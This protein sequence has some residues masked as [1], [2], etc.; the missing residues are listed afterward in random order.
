MSLRQHQK[1]RCGNDAQRHV[2]LRLHKS[3]AT[4]WRAMSARCSRLRRACR[5]VTYSMLSSAS[6]QISH[7]CFAGRSALPLLFVSVVANAREPAP[8]PPS[9]LYG[10]LFHRVQTEETF[11]RQQDICRCDGESR[12]P[13][14]SCA[15][16]RRARISRDFSLARFRG[17]ELRHSGR[18]GQRFQD[19]A[20]RRSARARRSA[21]GRADAGAAGFARRGF[22]ASADDPL[23]GAG[24]TLSRAVLL[25]FLLHDGGPADQR[26]STIS[27][28]TWSKTSPASSIATGTSRMAAAAT[29]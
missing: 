19:H 17:R 29:T 8:R 20:A 13:R 18:R 1:N 27:W 12:R 11:R 26:P 23:R 25:G 15:G 21:L 6:R 5:R 22:A 3:R 28:P 7:A 4:L 2:S 24:R 14:K 9:Q 16:T 10:A